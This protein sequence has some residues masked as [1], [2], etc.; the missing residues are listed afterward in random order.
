MQD[1]R[2]ILFATD[3]S[4]ASEQI[5]QR[6]VSLAH[7]FGAR[8]SL[9]YIVEHVP[10]DFPSDTVIPEQLDGVEVLVENAA[11]RLKQLAEQLGIPEAD[12]W[13]EVGSPKNEITRMASEKQVDLIVIGSHGR[14]GLAL[15]LGSTANA[16][17]HMAP[18]DVLAVKITE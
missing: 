14:H 1:Y 2:H 18:C 8:L 7:L 10:A 6:A 5:G 16:V 3:F 9:L 11:A 15:L 17:L 4:R 12:R 13:V